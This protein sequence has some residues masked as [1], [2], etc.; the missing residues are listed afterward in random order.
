MMK[1]RVLGCDGGQLPGFSPV[2]FFINNE[3]ILDAGTITSALSLKEQHKIQNILITHG[4]LD[5]IKDI[6][7]L[8]ENLFL[9]GSY[10]T[11]PIYSSE[12]ILSDITRNIFNGIIW[13]NLSKIPSRKPLFTLRSIKKILRLNGLSVQAVSVDHSHA[14][15]GY[16][17]SDQKSS[18]IFSGDTGPTHQLWK[19]ANQLKNLKAVFIELSFPSALADLGWQT[20]HL[21][22]PTLLRE[23]SK[24]KNQHIPIYLYHLKPVY[25]QKIKAEIQK[26]GLKRLRILTPKT[27]LHF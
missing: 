7:F 19:E 22:V 13:P 3:L 20:R 23:L 17:I 12:A 9:S 2:S 16:I 24:I 14:A 27:T 10:E 1:I 4:H 25:F 11:I 8:G 6:C 18:V 26:L 15:L 5:H 21:S